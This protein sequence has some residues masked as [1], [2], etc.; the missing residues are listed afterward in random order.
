MGQEAYYLVRTATVM[1]K[2][3]GSSETASQRIFNL[4]LYLFPKY[5]RAAAREI[6][7]LRDDEAFN[8]EKIAYH[9]LRAFQELLQLRREYVE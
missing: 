1:G 7:A 5:L 9:F 8:R 6:T 3:Q 4:P 2:I